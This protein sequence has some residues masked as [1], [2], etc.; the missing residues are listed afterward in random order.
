MNAIRHAL[1]TLGA[2]RRG[3]TA[4]EY[5]LICGLIVVVM[6]AGLKTLASG[7]GSMWGRILTNVS[8]VM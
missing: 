2:D 3:A 8:G 1:R 6:I 5:G 7:S 4:I